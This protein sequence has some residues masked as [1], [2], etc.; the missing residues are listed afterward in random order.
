MNSRIIKNR[1]PEAKRMVAAPYRPRQKQLLAAVF[2][3]AVLG[4]VVMAFLVTAY[5]VELWQQNL[6]SQ[7]NDLL[8]Q[9]EHLVEQVLALVKEIETLRHRL[10]TVGTSAEIDRKAATDLQLE[11]QQRQ[12][13]IEALSEEL[14]LYRN[15][16][17]PKEG[18]NGLDVHK[19]LVYGLAEARHFRYR[20]ILQQLGTGQRVI[21]VAVAAVIQ[22]TE[23]G[24]EVEYTAAKLSA[25]DTPWDEKV[26]FRYYYDLEGR[27]VL[28]EGFEPE[29]IV[30]TVKASRKAAKT[31]TFDWISLETPYVW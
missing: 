2:V 10:V 4:S 27:L 22:G 8:D 25:E 13:Q 1:R 31:Y 19:F 12:R 7:R 5:R 21:S 18:Q 15:L 23:A 3:L 29:T 24:A 17:N 30:V 16:M 11:V 14:S 28:P 9:R 20:L 26:K 6:H